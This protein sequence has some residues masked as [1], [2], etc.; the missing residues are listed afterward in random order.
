MRRSL[1]KLAA[2]LLLVAYALSGVAP[3]QQ[4]VVCLEPDGTLALEAAAA[5]RCSPCDEPEESSPRVA[6]VDPG[7][8]DCIDVLLPARSE[9]PQTS[10]ESQEVSNLLAVVAL[11]L[12]LLTIEDSEPAR[13]SLRACGEPRPGPNLA[14]IRT[15]VL[16]V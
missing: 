16:R 9:A 2:R 14:L 3:A 7:C 10:A 6:R 11:P 12:C 15:V 13:S 8:C 1:H 4:L 5:R